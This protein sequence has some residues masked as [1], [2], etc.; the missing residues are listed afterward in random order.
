MPRPLKFTPARLRAARDAKKMTQQEFA[1]FLG[2]TRQTI[3]NWENGKSRIPATVQ[4][5]LANAS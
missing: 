5:V 4:M 2:V 3:L 1:K